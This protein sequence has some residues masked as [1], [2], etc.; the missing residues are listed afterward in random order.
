MRELEFTVI[1]P[2]CHGGKSLVRALNSLSQVEYP[3]DSFE[4]IVAGT[5]D[6]EES[7]NTVE[8]ES[9]RSA[10][11]I[12]YI[13]CSDR[14]RVGALNA[15]CSTARGRILVFADDD[16]IFRENWLEKFGEIF[17]REDNIG[18]V[19]GKDELEQKNS[20]FDLALD[21]TLN[22]FFGTGGLRK[23]K[24]P[25]AGKYYPKLWNMAILR[26]VALS[27]SFKTGKGLTQVFDGSLSVHED[28]DL[29][30]RI[31]QSGRRIIYAPEIRVGHERDTTFRSFV[32]RNFTMARVCRALGV[33][34]LPHLALTTFALGG[35]TLAIASFFVT[36]LRD[37][38]L[39]CL[40][41]YFAILLGVGIDG[42]RRSGSL[43]VLAIT[44]GLLVSLHLARGLGYLFPWDDSSTKVTP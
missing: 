34:R 3:A 27:V 28:V 8:A 15:A 4:V 41:I 22:S 2:V 23:G 12:K 24:G 5:H 30:D 13:G 37:V 18:I 35:A 14:K 9:A 43:R 11:G 38:L 20:A 10:L 6:D 32:R 42:F 21:I 39:V 7:K 26:E 29:A 19:G 36:P 1:L 17:S 25:R 16:C 40:G 31:E 33:H 44:P